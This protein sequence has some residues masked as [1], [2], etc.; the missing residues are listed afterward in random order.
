MKARGIGLIVALAAAA[1][2]GCG[3]DDDGGSGGAAGSPEGAAANSASAA[4]EL[5]TVKEQPADGAVLGTLN[6]MYANL[7]AFDVQIKAQEAQAAGDGGGNLP[8]G[9]MLP[10]GGQ[11]PGRLTVRHDAL[12]E[13]CITVD[14]NTGST[15]FDNCEEGG[16]TFN[17]SVT[18][19]GDQVSVD[20]QMVVDPSSY[21]G[22]VP[23]GAP[24]A[25]PSI[26][27]VRVTE[28]T[29]TPLTVTDTRID[30][31][32]QVNIMATIDIPMLGTQTLPTNLTATYALELTDGC[33]T[34]GTLAIS[35]GNQS[36]TATF[37]PGCNEVTIE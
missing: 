8:G 2:A 6:K 26:K 9:G 15:T 23:A 29:P 35:D 19:N 22:A 34:G 30:G 5:N 25:A 4:V 24:G 37:G 17:G 12:D 21:A 16:A 36:H 1:L 32:F 20:V 18:V 31:V 7:Q 28:K 27:E 11:I 3:D 14:M 10:G 33:A 13:A